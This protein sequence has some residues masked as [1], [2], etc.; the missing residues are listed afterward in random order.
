MSVSRSHSGIPLSDVRFIVWRA[1]QGRVDAM[2]PFFRYRIH[3]MGLRFPYRP[4]RILEYA[5]KSAA[6]L[7]VLAVHRP[8]V[9]WLQL[10]PTPLLYVAILAK[11]VRLTRSLVADCHNSILMEPWVRSPLL[12][13]SLGRSVSVIIFHNQAIMEQA[14]TKGLRAQK[15]CVLEDRPATPSQ[16][17]RGA[18]DKGDSL[19]LFPAS[20]DA[21]EP[22]T[23]LLDAA[24][25]MP[26]VRFV[27]T[28]E[29]ARAKGRHD[30]TVRPRN[31]I[32]TGWV[33]SDEY[34]RLLTDADVVI[35]LTTQ[36]DTQ[37][38]VAGEAVGYGKAMVLSDT[39][40]LRSLYPKGAIHTRPDA[41][42]LEESIRA[43]LGNRVQLER[44][45]KQLRM[46]RDRHWRV[47]AQC[48]VDALR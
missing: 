28:G 9:T 43:A 24:G 46:E 5:I 40:T 33:D 1:Y 45:A 32:M 27:V 8:S 41:D 16:G 6:T 36:E 23:A 42:A 30:L 20:F 14:L 47:Q 18:R 22:L 17:E 15:C 37:T 39:K 31:V 34:K 44:E 12:S 7:W 11:R 35:S 2:Q 19:V 21:D 4:L 29:T 48:V 25:R 26:E 10:P 13:Q 38:S 3:W